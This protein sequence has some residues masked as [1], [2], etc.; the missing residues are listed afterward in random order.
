[1]VDTNK[2][3]IIPSIRTQRPSKDHQTVFKQKPDSATNVTKA[4]DIWMIPGDDDMIQH[5]RP[6]NKSGPQDIVDLWRKEGD[7]K[8]TH[9][10]SYII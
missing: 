9:Q 8:Y 2:T 7:L 3:I 4:S 5:I 6:L 10:K 1:M